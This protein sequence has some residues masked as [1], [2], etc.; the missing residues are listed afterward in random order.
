MYRSP[1]FQTYYESLAI[2]GEDR[3]VRNRLEDVENKDC[4]RAKTGYIANTSS[5]SGY[6]DGPH[7][8]HLIAFSFLVN[9]YS[10]ATSYVTDWHDSVV[11]VL[12][13]EY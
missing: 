6:I 11:S 12:L 10:C 7:S 1:N 9:N 13:S 4:V 3:S 2:P 5:L 8:G